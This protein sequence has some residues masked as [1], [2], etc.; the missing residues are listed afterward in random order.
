VRLARW[1]LALGLAASPWVPSAFAQSKPENVNSKAPAAPVA[2]KVAC[3]GDMVAVRGTCIDRY[4]AY[5]V[6][7]LPNGRTRAHSPYEP[8]GQ[9]RV[10]AMNARGRVPQGYISR[11][12][13]EGA[14][15]AAGKRLC[16]D[17][18]WLTACKGRRETQWPYGDERVPG[19]CNDRGTSSFNLLYGQD[20]GPPPQSLYNHENM[21][22][23][24]LNQLKGTLAK[25]G[26]FGRCKTSDGVFDM[27]GNLH[28]WTADPKGTFRGGYY[29]DVEINGQG[30]E[31][32]TTA[33]HAR[34]HDYSTG[35]RCCKTPGAKPKKDDARVTAPKLETKPL[36]KKPAPKRAT[37]RPAPDAVPP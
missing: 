28:E 20:G 36:K 5:V 37:T 27:V 14:C 26:T 23:S 13:A 4:E 31:Y 21:N 3:P 6:E 35:F 1:L 17:V 15:L 16:S 12:E 29:L 34:Y 32:R 7:L 30:C 19:R 11:D 25:S 8:I 33:H 2:R 18:E 9:R 22:D 24:R 10:K